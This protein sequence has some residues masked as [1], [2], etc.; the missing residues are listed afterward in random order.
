MKQ[1]N[2]FLSIVILVAV[3]AV[4]YMF[5][6]GESKAEYEQ[7]VLDE[8]EKQFKF[9][10][11]NETSPL[12]NEQKQNLE[13]LDFFPVKQKFSVRARMIPL[14]NQKILELAMTDGSTESYIRHS[15]VE[16]E[17]E[18]LTRRLLLLQ[19]TDEPDKKKFFL[20]FADETSGKSTYGG[21]RYINLRQ[22]G[23]SSITID[24]NLAYNPYCAYNPDF[25]CPIPPKENILGIA[26]T[27]GE[28][29]YKE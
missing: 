6:G 9:L 14:E 7:K 27:A 23:P 19:A 17:L 15:Y 5:T 12:T 2:I 16:F 3:A 28:K 10:K 21:G 13:G 29:N 22:D 25:A 26:I 20:A 18:G 24:F 1:K 4:A 11:Y 8:R